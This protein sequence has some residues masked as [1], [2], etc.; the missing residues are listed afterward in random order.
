MKED[1]NTPDPVVKV[2]SPEDQPPTIKALG[3]PKMTKKKII[4]LS[5]I[6]L[7]V[8]GAL[9]AL[10][11]LNND[12]K[13]TTQTSPVSKS[14]SVKPTPKKDALLIYSTKLGKT[15]TVQTKNLAKDT[16][17]VEVSFDEKYPFDTSS[18]NY[19]EAGKA[20]ASLSPNGSEL[21]YIR[22]DNLIVR[23]VTTDKENTIIKKTE[24]N[25]S[26]DTVTVI[27]LDPAPTKKGGPGL[28]T[29]SS[30]V[31][32][33]DGKHIGFSQGFYEGS[34]LAVINT[35]SKSYISLGD[36][37]R[38]VDEVGLGS[39]LTLLPENKQLADLGIY[40]DYLVKEYI[41]LVSPVISL[42]G[43]NLLAIQCPANQPLTGNDTYLESAF[44]AAEV[45]NMKNLRDCGEPGDHTLIN[46]SLSTGEYKQIGAGKFG[47][48]IAL[49]TGNVVYVAGSK[50]NGFK[51]TRISLKEV[52]GS[53]ILDSRELAS[54][55][56]GETVEATILK[57]VS[58]LPI[59]EIYVKKGSSH[60]VKVVNLQSKK[61]VSSI[62]LE[63][64]TG[65]DT[66]G[67]SQ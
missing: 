17:A 41:A 54:L 49:Q 60:S 21:A 24:T 44:S 36:T 31:W 7:I 38:Y 28:S 65:Y 11:L 57:T 16:T 33:R 9:L 37:F 15:S 43:K 39:K 23:N 30:P 52:S 35:S 25:G 53:S 56:D 12:N 4:I 2:E 14:P 62:S 3:H 26:P 32:S 45:E 61:L 42:D 64:N 22:D 51:I 40:G 50:N 46:G 1:K 10:F 66:L 63:A 67:I 27:K 6:V 20:A 55:E 58:S 34:G 8:I 13:S 19:W 59:A 18:G 5:L 48:S 29:I 47:N